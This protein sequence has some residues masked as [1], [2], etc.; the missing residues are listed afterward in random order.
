VRQ[1]RPWTNPCCLLV[2]TSLSWV[3][4]D[5]GEMRKFLGLVMYM[6]LI[7]VASIHS[8]WKQ[9]ALYSNSLPS[10]TMS[11]NRFQLLLKM[12]HF[13][14]VVPV[15]SED[16]LHKV[17][18]FTDLLIHTFD[19]NQ[20]GE[21]IVIDES[22]VLFKQYLPNKS[23]K[24]GIK[25]FKLTD[26][27]GYTYK[28]IIY[29]GK[30]TSREQSMNLATSIVLQLSDSCLDSGRTLCTDNFYT[31]VDLAEQLLQRNTHILGTLRSNVKDCLRH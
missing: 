17:R 26:L 3:D 31:S 10:K 14:P 20:P 30:T 23:H 19:G 15:N 4:T 27:S 29:E 16:R 21:Y 2:I 22:M 9:N 8:Y 12:W 13:A 7:N 25:L 5:N 18:S 1:E 6:G 24:Y 28:V 11:R